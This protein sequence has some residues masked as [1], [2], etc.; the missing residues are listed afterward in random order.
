MQL[1][2]PMTAKH[3]IS[4]TWMEDMYSGSSF[5]RHDISCML[6]SV[7]YNTCVDA[8]TMVFDNYQYLISINVNLTVA[9]QGNDLW[10]CVASMRPCLLVLELRNAPPVS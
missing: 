10:A 2:R 5:D 7:H 8:Q 1:A 6:H 4:L 9:L 3:L